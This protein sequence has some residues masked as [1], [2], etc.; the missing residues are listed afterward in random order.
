MLSSDRSQ[1]SPNWVAMK[2]KGERRDEDSVA[3]VQSDW[4]ALTEKQ[5][6]ANQLLQGPATQILLRGGSRSGKTFVLCRAIILRATKAPGST[7]TILRHRLNAL[8]VSVIDDTMPTVMR[9][10][11]PGVELKM[12]GNP[13]IY[14]ELPNGSRIIYGG[15]DDKDRTE[16]ILGQ[17]HSTIYF[18]ECSQITYAARNKAL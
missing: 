8:H 1:P 5:L 7:H 15:L 18:N 3:Q 13:Y 12:R 17:E 10:C 4:H 14:H 6:L 2:P 9:E 11:F 16:K